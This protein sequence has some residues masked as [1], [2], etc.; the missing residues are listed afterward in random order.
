MSPGTDNYA[1][2]EWLTARKITRFKSEIT[3]K[4]SVVEI[5]LATTLVANIALYRDVMKN[6]AC[7]LSWYLLASIP[8]NF[9]M[10]S[11]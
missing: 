1:A 10:P 2:L 6:N 11:P 4:E 5:I 9:A 7:Y 8:S 3:G